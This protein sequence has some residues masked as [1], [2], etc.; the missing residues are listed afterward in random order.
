MIRSGL[1]SPEIEIGGGS[2]ADVVQSLPGEFTVP[3]AAAVGDLMYSSGSDT[4]ARA[5]NASISTVPA[6][7]VVVA[8]PTS[9]TATVV[10]L[11][12]VDVFAGLTPGADYYVGTSGALILASSL[13]SAS[14]S[15]AQK[16]G[17]ALA[18][19]A[20]LFEPGEIVIL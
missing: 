2:A 5:D 4:L 14:G 17:T 7:A 8:K 18:A 15:V 13:P 11:G 10:Y 19:D 6:I 1:R 20:L 16:I 3:S 12:R 9:T